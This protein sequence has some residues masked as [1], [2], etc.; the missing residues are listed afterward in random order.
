MI[1]KDF[2]IGLYHKYKYF[3]TF[4]KRRLFRVLSSDETINYILKN[5]CSLARFGDGE[6]K[7]AMNFIS[8]QSKKGIGFQEYNESL[9][10]RMFEILSTSDSHIMIGL[11]SPIFGKSLSRMKGFARQYWKNQTIKYIDWLSQN[12][13][14]RQLFL[15]SFFT[16]FYIDFTEHKRCRQ[17]VDHLKLI[18]E[19]R[20]L[21]IVE[22]ALTRLGIGNDLFENAKSIKRIVCPPSNAYDRINDIESAI[23]SIDQ[24]A[25][26]L[27]L[28]ALGPTAT[29]IAYDMSKK[30]IQTIDIGH[31]DVEYEWMLRNATHKIPIPGKFVNEA[32]D[33]N[34][35]EPVDSPEYISQIIRVIQ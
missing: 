15:D 31:V 11:P 10:K 23:L 21:I 14:R 34:A 33:A 25:D 26:K 24:I 2:V 9:G 28:V 6:F 32:R 3:K 8:G 17:Y 7:L 27:V 12:I 29:V 20:N 4:R 22:G 16:R 1:M 35:Y 19:G 13:D 30:G 18:W 5:K